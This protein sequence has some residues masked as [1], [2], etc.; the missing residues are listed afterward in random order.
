M[1]VPRNCDCCAVWQAWVEAPHTKDERLKRY[2]SV[3]EAYRE[4]V[5]SHMRTVQAIEHFR[6][7]RAGRRG[8]SDASRALAKAHRK[9]DRDN[10]YG[11]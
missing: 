4:R 11:G 2:E 7:N 8:V 3:P 5:A 10:P 9:V 1:T 6:T